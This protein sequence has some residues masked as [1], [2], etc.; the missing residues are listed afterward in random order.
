MSLS[1]ALEIITEFLKSNF[2][3]NHPLLAVLIISGVIF[4]VLLIIGCMT[5]F[6]VGRG[7]RESLE[8]QLSDAKDRA[9][10]AQAE[11]H[12]LNAKNSH[13][14][15]ELK[16]LQQFAKERTLLH[17]AKSEPPQIDNALMPF[18]NEKKS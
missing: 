14:E 13:L 15:S 18:I 2:S 5:A 1:E 7:R 10:N 11:I 16:E 12:V 4:L 6:R 9:L 3:Q 8:R 17:G